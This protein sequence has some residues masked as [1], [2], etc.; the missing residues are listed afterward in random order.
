MRIIKRLFIIDRKAS[1]NLCFRAV[2]AETKK[3]LIIFK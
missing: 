3:V 1:L 2:L